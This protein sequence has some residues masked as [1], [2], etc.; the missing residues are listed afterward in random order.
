[1]L[2]AMFLVYIIRIYCIHGKGELTTVWKLQNTRGEALGTFGR[3]TRPEGRNRAKML[4]KTF[5][6]R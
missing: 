4:R 1:M 6:R 5:F 2:L 3:G